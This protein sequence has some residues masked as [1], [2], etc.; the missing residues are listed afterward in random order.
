MCTDLYKVELQ[1][2]ASIEVSSI[3]HHHC[4]SQRRQYDFSS[5]LLCKQRRRRNKKLISLLFVIIIILLLQVKC[6]NNKNVYSLYMHIIFIHSMYVYLPLLCHSIVIPSALMFSTTARRASFCHWLFF[7]CEMKCCVREKKLQFLFWHTKIDK[8]TW[9]VPIYYYY[10]VESERATFLLCLLVLYPIKE[11]FVQLKQWTSLT[12]FSTDGLLLLH[13]SV[14]FC[15]V[16]SWLLLV[17][18]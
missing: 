16:W 6:I 13:L 12:F 10:R 3:K 1:D 18:M 9:N 8:Y 14:C 7:C 15:D 2:M 11:F 17:N 5:R 4:T